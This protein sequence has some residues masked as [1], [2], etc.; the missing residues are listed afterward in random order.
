VLAA[1]QLDRLG[2]VVLYAVE[3]VQL[4]RRDRLAAG[5]LATLATLGD[6][7]RQQAVADH[8]DKYRDDLFLLK[9][10]DFETE[11]EYRVVLKTDDQAPVGYTT[12][13]MGYAYVPY[14]DALVAVVVGRHFPL[15]QKRGA[16][17]FCDGAGVKLLRMWWEGGTPL[18]LWTAEA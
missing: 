5:H 18:L 10:D 12:D 13:E 16:R 3:V 8:I 1:A 6:Q 2:A 9:S 17:E 4:D 14:G 15:W 11:A 7:H